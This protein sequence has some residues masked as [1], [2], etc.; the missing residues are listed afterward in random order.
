MAVSSYDA[1]GCFFAALLATVGG[2]LGWTTLGLIGAVVGV[3]LGCVG[4]WFVGHLLVEANFALAIRGEV[5]ERRRA[6]RSIFGEYWKPERKAD[7][8]RVAGSA[9]K[10]D[11][12]TGRVVAQFY[13]G[14]VLDVGL[15]FPAVL[16]KLRFEQPFSENPPVGSEVT[17]R[18]DESR[19]ANRE[20][21]LTQRKTLAEAGGTED[22]PG[23]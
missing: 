4:G 16:T 9:K 12:L 5:R 19:E 11:S 21:H 7:W 2:W 3:P 23:N 20:F 14:V 18:I 13:C 15:G 10:G 6:L 22:A 8:V 17:A 1:G